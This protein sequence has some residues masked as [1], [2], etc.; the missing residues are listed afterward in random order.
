MAGPISG[1]PLQQHIRIPV[2]GLRECLASQLVQGR[3]SLCSFPGHAPEDTPSVFLHP[4]QGPCDDLEPS[5]EVLDLLGG[6]SHGVDS[7]RGEEKGVILL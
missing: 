6:G 4:D 5:L 3:I 2:C 7:V 1:I